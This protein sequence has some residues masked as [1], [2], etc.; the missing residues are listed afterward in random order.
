[1]AQNPENSTTTAPPTPPPRPQFFAGTITAI[2]NEQITIS[3]TLVGHPPDT[4]SFHL[5]S[6]T[7]MN[8]ASC[9][10]NTKVTVRYQRLPE[11]D[12]ALQVLLHPGN[13][14][15]AKHP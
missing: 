5:T 6:K 3:R 14:P 4:R 11:G 15:P 13:K 1:L 7:K 12:I 8:K 2:N 9:K 10:V